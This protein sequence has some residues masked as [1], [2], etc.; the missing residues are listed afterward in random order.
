MSN[1]KN[2]Y[3]GKDGRWR[4][5]YTDALGKHHTVSYPRLL[6]EERLGRKLFPYED[7]HHIDGNKDNNNIE[8]LKVVNH[9]EHQRNHMAEKAKYVS[10]VQKCIV[11]G[12]EFIQTPYAQ[13]RYNT[14]IKRGKNRI[15]SCSKSCSSKYGRMVQLGRI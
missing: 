4:A 14:D 15:L 9:G 8:N 10:L 6:I 2:I 3:K 12:K 13:S 11:C 7:V 5:Y 1:I